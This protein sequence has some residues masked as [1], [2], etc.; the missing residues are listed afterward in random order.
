MA[1]M[2][3]SNVV[4][5]TAKTRSVFY[6]VHIEQGADGVRSVKVDDIDDTPR[7]RESVVWALREAARII[8]ENL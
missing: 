3:D 8:E 2:S 4:D 7:D 1:A 5:L 6:T